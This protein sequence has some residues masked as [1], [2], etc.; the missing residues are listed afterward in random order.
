MPQ[1]D[2]VTGEDYAQRLADA[3]VADLR[4][5]LENFAPL[6]ISARALPNGDAVEVRVRRPS[7]GADDA[8][9]YS[10]NEQVYHYVPDGT[11]VEKHAGWI[12]VL[13]QEDHTWLVHKGYHGPTLPAIL[14]HEDGTM[15]HVTAEEVERRGLR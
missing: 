14:K 7:D 4:E 6:Q 5:S 9:T 13:F 1:D 15:E 8:E 12:S 3:V 10:I 11:N 2:A